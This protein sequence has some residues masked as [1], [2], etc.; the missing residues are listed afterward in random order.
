M[1]ILPGLKENSASKIASMRIP[2][3]PTG[4]RSKRLA[5]IML[6]LWWGGLNCLTG[7][8]L[9][10]PDTPV[11]S[12]CSMS[13]GDAEEDCCQSSARKQD[14]STGQFIGA[15]SRVAQSQ[16]CCSLEAYAA[17]VNRKPDLVLGPTF[18]GVANRSAPLLIGEQH[19]PQPPTRWE[20]P[21]DR[22][23]TYLRCCVLLI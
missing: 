18:I 16:S 17:D 2:S 7:C 22:G 13:G 6:I 20:R 10:M 8:A 1:R 23:S 11:E 19:Q 12:H 14:S 5:A 15:S 9:T 21:P 4:E 3:S